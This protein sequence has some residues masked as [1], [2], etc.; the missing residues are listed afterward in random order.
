MCGIVGCFGKALVKKDKEFFTQSLIVDMLR[1]F[2]STGIA[3]WHSTK[4]VNVLKRAMHAMDFI[5]FVPYEATMSPYTIEGLLGHNRAATKGEVIHKNA[6][7]F[8]SPNE[9][10]VLVHNGTLYSYQTLSKGDFDVD[11]EYIA[12]GIESN[13]AKATAEALFGKYAVVYIN[14]FDETLNMFRNSERPLHYV[15]SSDRKM[16]YFHS[17]PGSLRWLIERNSINIGKN[18]IEE[19]PTGVIMTWDLGAIDKKP[20]VITF[21]PANEK[22]YNYN[23]N[24]NNN[25]FGNS[26]NNTKVLTYNNIKE[27]DIGNKLYFV[28]TS[29]KM[30]G[31]KTGTVWGI[32]Q[33]GNFVKIEDVVIN[34]FPWDTVRMVGTVKRIDVNKEGEIKNI[35][36]LGTDSISR[37][38]GLAFFC[39]GSVEA[40][41][42]PRFRLQRQGKPTNVP[43]KPDN[44]NSAAADDG[45][46]PTMGDKDDY[47]LGPGDI[48]IPKE[49]WYNLTSDGCINCGQ[50]LSIGDHALVTWHPNNSPVWPMC[51]ECSDKAGVT[52]EDPTPSVV[53]LLCKGK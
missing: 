7:P 18:E 53:R 28:P 35:Y 14:V 16:I 26:S 50:V 43:F 24:N 49:E 9:T 51:A 21:T 4:K 12:A 30:T 47:V 15:Y 20:R 6:H 42:Q 39:N 23:S 22:H 17:E 40:T 32:T 8:I 3:T 13:G 25:N 33:K 10:I 34:K 31:R 44:T 11:S 41:K 46:F 48:Y 5:Q 27:A 52:P 36:T 38:E 37:V 29:F 2:D 19:L 45:V 1:G